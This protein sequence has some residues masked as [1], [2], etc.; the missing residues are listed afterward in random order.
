MSRYLPFSF[1]FGNFFFTEE[2]GIEVSLNRFDPGRELP[3]GQ[4]SV[5]TA[6]LPGDFVVPICF[7]FLK[8]D[9]TQT[10][11]EKDFLSAFKVSFEKGS[12]NY[13]NS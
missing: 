7:S 1:V 11:G 4:G 8:G 5:L 6:K 12:V 2:E 13:F 10:H 9:K 3:S